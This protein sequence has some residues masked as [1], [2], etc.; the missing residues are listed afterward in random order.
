MNNSTLPALPP[1]CEIQLQN[2]E[3]VFEQP[4]QARSFAMAVQLNESGFFTWQEWADELSL[5]I[6]EIEKSS[7][8]CDAADYYMAWQASLENL[9]SKKLGSKATEA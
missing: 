1:N 6:A 9:V 3:P 5:H 2:G 8:I 7:P 4:W